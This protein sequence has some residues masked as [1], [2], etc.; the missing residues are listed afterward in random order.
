MSNRKIVCINED[1][2]AYEF[3]NSKFSPFLILDCEGVYTF[4]DNVTLSDNVLTDG[5]TYIGSVTKSRN[6]VIKLSVKED[7][8]YTRQ[9]LYTLF[10]PKLKGVFI[11]EENDTKRRIDYVVESV[12]FSGSATYQIASIS[13]LCP[14]PFFEDLE[15]TEVVMSGWKSNFK[16]PFFLTSSGDVFGMKINNKL[17]LINDELLNVKRLGVTI[18]MV[19]E[20]TIQ[21]PFIYHVETEEYLKIG[22]DDKPFIMQVN[23]EVIINTETNKKSVYLKRGD[24]VK[25][26]NEYLSADVSFIQL[27]NGCNHFRFG[28]DTNEDFLNVTVSFKRKFLGV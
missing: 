9:L 3:T 16:F 11:Y 14:S 21:N 28:S 19:A 18:K 7:T 10:K 22:T 2:S 24:V 26:I 1:G 8:Q 4:S 17:S 5:A 12:S 15:N 27:V 20:H 13:L 23:D 6:I 25:N